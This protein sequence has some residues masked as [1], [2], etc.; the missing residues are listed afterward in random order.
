MCACMCTGFPSSLGGL[1]FALEAAR[2]MSGLE[3]VAERVAPEAMFTDRKSK[4]FG[5]VSVSRTVSVETSRLVK[6]FEG[7]RRRWLATTPAPEWSQDCFH[8][9][10]WRRWMAAP[11]RGGPFHVFVEARRR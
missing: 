5:A 6:G 1:G 4:P 2:M 7:L 10:R 9:E 8:E 11:G 3:P